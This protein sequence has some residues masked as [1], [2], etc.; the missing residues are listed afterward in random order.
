MAI[1]PKMVEFNFKTAGKPT[2]YFK[3]IIMVYITIINS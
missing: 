1:L 3:L 2:T